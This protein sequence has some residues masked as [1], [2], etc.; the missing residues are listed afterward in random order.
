MGVPLKAT[1]IRTGTKIEID[2]EVYVCT[3]YE[4]H[5][6][7]KG[8]AVVRLKIKH[9]KTGRVLD[10]TVKSGEMLNKADLQPREVQYLY[11][12]DQLHFM[13]SET[14]EQFSLPPESLLGKEVWL[15]DNTDLTL[16]F[17]NDEPVDV[18]MPLHMV[19]EVIETEPGLKGDT[20]SGGNKPAKVETGAV[21]QVPLFVNEGDK[22]KVDTRDGSYIERA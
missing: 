3:K 13:D 20:V 15:K 12:D 10:K 5:A 22:I 14:Y 19:F 16:L 1:E 4:H 21:I 11:R 2:G 9:M 7:G 8:Q 6:P 17:H 18:D